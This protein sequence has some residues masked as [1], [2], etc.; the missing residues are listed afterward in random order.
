MFLKR[1]RLEEE[2]K[3]K[4]C[5]LID[6][7]TTDIWEYMFK[8]RILLFGHACVLACINR[9]LRYI[10]TTR[11]TFEPMLERFNESRKLFRNIYCQSCWTDEYVLTPPAWN[12]HLSVNPLPVCHGCLD[13]SCWKSVIAN[14][15]VQR[16][17]SA[18]TLNSV[19]PWKWQWENIR[20][21]FDILPVIFESFVMARVL[22]QELP[23]DVCRQHGQPIA[24]AL[25][26]MLSAHP[27]DQRTDAREFISAL[28]NRTALVPALLK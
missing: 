20:S 12:W 3:E 15:T 9:R 26:S 18:Y 4:P 19:I 6:L 16:I 25:A 17:I 1:L 24:R 5:G 2:E 23:G 8:R 7:L 10:M 28:L 13:E 27:L 21:E 22:P 14:D 11:I